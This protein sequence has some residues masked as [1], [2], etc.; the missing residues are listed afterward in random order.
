MNNTE[1][2]IKTVLGRQT[3]RVPFFIHWAM[4]AWIPT[5]RNW[6]KQG[7]KDGDNWRAELEEQTGIK[8]DEG[9]IS[10]GI[11]IGRKE[12]VNLGFCPFFEEEVI[13]DRG[14]KH[15][16]RDKMGI[17]QLAKKD[18]DSIPYFLDYPIKNSKDWEKIRDEKL[19]PDNPDR[20]PANWNELVEKFK[21]SKAAIQIGE[22]P[23]G[24]F[25]TLRDFMGVE[26]FLVSL[27]TQKELIHEIMDYLTDFWITIYKKVCKDIKIHH[28]HIWE[29]MSG[30]QGSLISPA[31]VREFMLPNYKK[32]RQFA[33]DNGIEIISVDTDG[34]VDELVPIFIEGGINLLFPFEVAAGSDI[35]KVSRQ[36]P[37]LCIMG[38]IDKRE[39]AK[40][41]SAIDAELKRVSSMFKGKRYIPGLDHGIPPDVSWDNFKYYITRLHDYIS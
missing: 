22:Y 17:V 29:D 5:R 19:N 35:V 24:L 38:G 25:G 34:N 41:K 1:R 32:I 9:F 39:L 10:V 16:I 23:F 28:I 11:D 26:E 31:M 4:N 14:D 3:D 30:R 37:E 13:E 7:V 6:E 36:Y 40:D 12:G 18:R 21:D 33:D 2:I 15:I 8:L 20:F 27:Y